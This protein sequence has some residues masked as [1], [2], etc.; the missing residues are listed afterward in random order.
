MKIHGDHCMTDHSSADF[1][2]ETEVYNRQKEALV[3]RA[4]GQFVVVHGDTLIGPYASYN[5]AFNEGVRNFGSVPMLIKQILPD[6]PI[7]FAPTVGTVA[8]D[9][10]L[11]CLS[12]T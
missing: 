6:D 11:S 5:D 3:Q 7:S 1:A 4:L 8:N 2:K 10:V 12:S 9:A